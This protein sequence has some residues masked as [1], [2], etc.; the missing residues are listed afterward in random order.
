MRQW[1]K[2]WVQ[3][4]GLIR[5]CAIKIERRREWITTTTIATDAGST[6]PDKWGNVE[7]MQLIQRFGILFLYFPVYD[8]SIVCIV[9][10][11]EKMIVFTSSIWICFGQKRK[12]RQNVRLLWLKDKRWN[13]NEMKWKR[14]NIY[15]DKARENDR[16]V[17]ERGMLENRWQTISN[18]FLCENKAN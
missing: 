10:G 6:M 3:F 15:I 17:C 4:I 11:T 1:A 9:T 8:S 14:N 7:I 12:L 16:D 5:L 13:G 18:A 2:V